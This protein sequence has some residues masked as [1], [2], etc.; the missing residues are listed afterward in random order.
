MIKITNLSYRY[1]DGTLAL[2]SVNLDIKKGEFVVIAGKNGCG[3]STLLRSINGLILPSEGSVAVNGMY[4]SDRS[5]VMD[6]RRMAGMIF[7][8][9]ESQFIGMTV[10]EDVAFGPENLSLS[11]EEIH[12]LVEKS[13]RAVEMHEFRDHTPRI[14]SGGQKQKIALASVLAMEPGIILLDEVTT[15]LD[16]D[17]RNEI[18]S[19][20]KR[21]HENGTTIVYVTHLLEELVHADRL[22]VMEEGRIMHDGDPRTILSQAKVTTF[23]FNLPP[24]IELSRKLRDSGIIDRTTFPLSKDELMEAL[25]QLK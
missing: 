22:V 7:Q 5:R 9:P 13:L 4:T 16:P 24:I 15:M 25:C 6:I 11:T 1:P 3:K 14:L 10:E 8:N 18:L 17:S 23:G 21:L 20:V 2:N 12:K 19:L